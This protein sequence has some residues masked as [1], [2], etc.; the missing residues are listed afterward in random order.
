MTITMTNRAQRASWP[1]WMT[2]RSRRTLPALA[3]APMIVLMSIVCGG[4]QSQPQN[5]QN[6][7]GA[8]PATSPAVAMSPGI[9]ASD[10]P[11]PTL[12]GVYTIS[13]VDD[14]GK[15]SMVSQDNQI[16]IV[17]EGHSF[18]RVV[19]EGGKVAHTDGGDYRLEGTDQLVLSTTVSDKQPLLTPAEKTHKFELSPDGEELKLWGTAGKVAVFRREARRK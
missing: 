9:A 16:T 6:A 2:K 1:R 17:F 8:V 11:R 13:E 12:S 7:S 10:S 18:T 4:C 14:N 19:K 15:A 3:I 5:N